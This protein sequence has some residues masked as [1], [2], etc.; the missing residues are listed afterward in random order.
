MKRRQKMDPYTRI[1]FVI[2]IICLFLFFTFSKANNGVTDGA[3]LILIVLRAL[4]LL[5]ALSCAL[6]VVR[7]LF[8]RMYARDS[9]LSFLPYS[10][11]AGLAIFILFFFE[12]LLAIAKFASG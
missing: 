7:V 11:P 12:Q 2:N 5:L 9:S 3:L 10:L 6:A 1:V 8:K 4:S